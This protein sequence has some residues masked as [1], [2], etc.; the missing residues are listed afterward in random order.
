M[1][2][3]V[4]RSAIIAGVL[5]LAL[6]ST[7][8]VAFAEEASKATASEEGAPLS[9]IEAA[10]NVSDDLTSAQAAVLSVE[11]PTQQQIR[12]YVVA[13]QVHPG[14]LTAFARESS[15]S[16]FEVGALTQGTTDSALK[17]LNLYRFVAGVPS[18]VSLD[19]SYS[20]MAQAGSLV[21]AA[22]NE[23]THTPSRPAGM[24]EALY[25]LGYSGTS[26]SNIHWSQVTGA[27]GGKCSL[28][29]SVISYMSD[30]GSGPGCVNFETVG[31]RRWCLNP[32]MGKTGFGAVDVD[33]GSVAC[34]TSEYSCMYAFDSSAPCSYDAVMWPAHNTP[35]ELFDVKD[36][37]SISAKWIDESTSVDVV[38]ARDAKRWHFDV[39]SSD[40]FFNVDMCLYGGSPAAI[41]WADD[42]GAYQVGDSYEIVVKTKS[43]TFS[44]AVNFFSIVH[45]DDIAVER[46]DEKGNSA[47]IVSRLEMSVANTHEEVVPWLIDSELHGFEGGRWFEDKAI[48][49]GRFTWESSNPS[50]VEV[51]SVEGM[52]RGARLDASA[53]GRATITVRESSGV[54]ASFFADVAGV[55][56]SDAE[57]LEPIKSQ[58]YQGA[59]LKPSFDL[60]VLRGGVS[61]WLQ[62]GVDYSASYLDNSAPGTGKIVV[63][64]KGF[65]TG[66]KTISF[67][68]AAAAPASGS[69][70][71]WMKDSRGWWLK[72]ADG[73][74][75]ASQWALVDGS[76]YLFDGSGYMRTG[77]AQVGGAWYYLSPSGAMRTGWLNLGGVWYWLGADGAMRTGWYTVGGEW[78]WSNSSGVWHPNRW[79]NDARG[80]WYS[81]AGGGYPLAANGWQK[82][83]GS[84]YLFD[85]SGYMRTGWAQVGGAWYYLSPSG[86]MRTGWLNLGGVWYWLGA[87]GAMRTGWYTVGGEWYHSDS[88][89]SLSVNAWID[90]VYWVGASGV[91]ATDARVDGGR[92]Y[93]GPDG[94]WI[95]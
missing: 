86:A 93:V 90:G 12:D 29:S 82:I 91:M 77:W 40:G 36:P 19:S 26:Q 55:P 57:L 60:V 74:Y 68:I 7:A 8:S 30:V 50:V 70:Q 18:N 38:R 78:N 10:A 58:T 85:G 52:G 23:L 39:D 16:S 21:M 42:L 2:K 41:F 79:V 54:A 6:A 25:S 67:A 32:A 88:S 35:C 24:S 87:D 13:H 4:V 69:G 47:G 73:T 56:I 37:W 22:N 61:C 53:A 62:E 63:V 3:R 17:V 92:Y 59:P 95:P 64:G 76:W 31:H 43:R 75:P 80:W 44:Y 34:G 72:R 71:K 94:V 83:D 45:A 28:A 11:Q 1:E 14:F 15:V 33:T 89:G 51:R 5:A 46:Y 66:T 81:W 20:E 65:Y 27:W 9:S 49:R 48:K 84:W